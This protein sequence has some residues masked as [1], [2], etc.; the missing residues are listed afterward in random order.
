[1]TEKL[2]KNE[3]K[4]EFIRL[5]VKGFSLSAIGA[6]LGKST[7]T[8]MEWKRELEEQIT[9]AEIAKLDNIRKEFFLGENDIL[10]SLGS[11][12]LDLR[13]GRIGKDFS[14][15]S[16]SKSVTLEL[17]TIGKA[18]D[19]WKSKYEFFNETYTKSNDDKN[20]DGDLDNLLSEFT[21]RLN[22]KG[23]KELEKFMFECVDKDY[24]LTESQI[25]NALK[26]REY[27]RQLI[28]EK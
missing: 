23:L 26:N 9:V 21:E 13:R 22:L 27:N 1:L 17:Q 15:L 25:E 11:L 16:L 2:G 8:M 10:E 5:R 3:L 12:I 28:E 4:E 7:P 20:N 19:V 6:K 14:E 18:I 24:F